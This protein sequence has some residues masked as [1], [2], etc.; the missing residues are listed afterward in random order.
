M[1]L[2]T[3][4]FEIF[5]SI[6]PP[7]AREIAWVGGRPFDRLAADRRQDGKH[8]GLGL[9]GSSARRNDPRPSRLHPTRQH[10]KLVA[11][12]F[13]PARPQQF[14]SRFLAREETGERQFDEGAASLARVPLKR[15]VLL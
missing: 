3:V 6:I 9:A 7:L 2:Q 15:V 8:E 13:E 1:L 5:G 4:Q 11:V 12:R 10:L 14:G